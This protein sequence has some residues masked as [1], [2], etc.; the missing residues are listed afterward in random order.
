MILGLRE[1]CSSCGPDSKLDRSDADSGSDTLFLLG[2]NTSSHEGN[3][4]MQKSDR[5]LKMQSWDL[6]QSVNKVQVGG[7]SSMWYNFYL[8][9]ARVMKSKDFFPAL[10]TDVP[11]NRRCWVVIKGRHVVQTQ[12]TNQELDNKANLGSTNSIMS[13]KYMR[14]MSY[15]SYQ[16]CLVQ[17][18]NS[19]WVIHFKA[20]KSLHDFPRPCKS[21]HALSHSLVPWLHLTCLH[22]P[23]H[24][25]SL[26]FLY[27]LL[28]SISTMFYEILPRQF[29]SECHL[30]CREVRLIP[31][32]SHEHDLILGSNPESAVH[33]HMQCK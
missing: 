28:L 29:Q 21:I 20:L 8:Y 33:S 12:C 31:S 15:S 30:Q 14:S 19:Q 11:P 32:K 16:Y 23:V 6:C 22:L 26:S 17:Y 13:T 25:L 10:R 18:M 7:A 3:M 27:K 4:S 5:L 2:V 24:L 9:C 1:W